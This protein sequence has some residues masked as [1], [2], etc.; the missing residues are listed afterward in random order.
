MF[1]IIKKI[2]SIMLLI[3]FVYKKDVIEVYYASVTM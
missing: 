2:S 1:Q 3:F